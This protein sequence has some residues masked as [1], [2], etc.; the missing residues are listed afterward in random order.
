MNMTYVMDVE[1]SNAQGAVM[2][3][4]PLTINLI[5]VDSSYVSESESE[6]EEEELDMS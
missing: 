1:L 3:F 4:V 2:T 5:V 6:V